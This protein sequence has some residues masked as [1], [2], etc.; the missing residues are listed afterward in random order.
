MASWHCD[1]KFDQDEPAGP[2]AML[3]LIE[4]G[5]FEGAAALLVAD[6]GGAPVDL[7]DQ[8]AWDA[9][10]AHLPTDLQLE[11]EDG[12]YYA[13]AEFPVQPAPA[14]HACGLCGLRAAL[15]KAAS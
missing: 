11:L 12:R 6:S 7:V 10:E 5:D 8:E 9:V 1:G 3:E 15:A 4:R 2:V 14:K 13:R